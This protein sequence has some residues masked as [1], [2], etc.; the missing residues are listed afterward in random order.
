MEASS[1]EEGDGERTGAM[2]QEGRTYELLDSVLGPLN[3]F[4]SSN[5]I[6]HFFF[7]AMDLWGVFRG[8]HVAFFRRILP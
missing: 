1:R 8:L 5:S 7:E 3:H 6:D 4:T 2:G